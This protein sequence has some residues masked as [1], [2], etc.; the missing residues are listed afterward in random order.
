M[1]V[2]CT[3]LDSP[4]GR[5]RLYG[6]RRALF[7]ILFESADPPAAIAADGPAVED[8]RAGALPEA[9]RQLREYFDGTRRA[10][11]L[12]LAPHGTPFQQ[13]VWRALARIPYGRTLAYGALARRIGQPGAARAV[14]MAN[15]RNPLP[16]IVPCHRV[17]G[18]DGSLTGYGG[19]LE[20]K[21]WLLA[22]EHGTA[23]PRRGG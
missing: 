19:G 10:F 21:R 6:D 5:L 2:H 1:T 15:N 18:A 16:I 22:L 14:G 7:A 3:N 23:L 9:V 4:I 12:P 11:D 17:I 8:P 20:R 13:K